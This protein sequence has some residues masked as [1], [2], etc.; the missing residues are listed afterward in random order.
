MTM[1]A[2]STI[3]ELRDVIRS[4]ADV[5][6]RLELRGGGSKAAIGASRD[7]RLVSMRRFSGIIDYDPA[8]LVLTVGA[9]TP[10]HEVEALVAGA[11][12]TL[13]FDPW[14]QGSLFGEQSG[15]ATIGGVIAAGVAGPRRLTL[16]APRDHLLGFEAVS[17]RGERF[18]AG[19]KVVKNV[20]GYDLSKL[21]A[22]S[23][24]RLAA[25]TELTLKLMPR[26]RY[27]ATLLIEN[28]AP[29]RALN[30]I[31]RA[32]ASQAEVCAAAYMPDRLTAAASR[33]ILCL[34]GFEPSVVARQTMLREKLG[35]FGPAAVTSG[36]DSDA[37]WAEVRTAARLPVDLPLWRI[38]IPASKA[39]AM[40]SDLDAA[41]ADYFCDWGGAL[42]WAAT[43]IDPAR[44]RRLAEQAGGHAMLMRGSR[45]LLDAVPAFHPRAPGVA[46][47]EQRIRRA[48]DPAQIFETGRFLE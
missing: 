14:D 47:L 36:D 15:K 39:P 27:S 11:G 20:T 22:G 26:P 40:I 6:E 31:A 32:M 10:L 3:D 2:P 21:M 44:V 23:W 41:G 42:I 4:A 7:A 43:D 46:A 17:G 38:S 45:A 37:L 33:T 16:G 48:F 18:I 24:G 35:E 25:M 8:E 19:G 12:Q 13:A 34:Q 30:A 29:A 1:V 5:G 28:L 9:G